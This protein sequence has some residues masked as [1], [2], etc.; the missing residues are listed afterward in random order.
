MARLDKD[1]DQIN[2]T[3]NAF[4]NDPSTSTPETL[5][6]MDS[7][8]IGTHK[9][10]N[11]NVNAGGVGWYRVAYIDVTRAGNAAQI[12]HSVGSVYLT[13]FYTGYKPSKG[14]FNYVWDGGTN[15]GSLV[16]TAGV[17]STSPTR[18]RMGNTSTGHA[19]GQGYVY[20]DLYFSNTNANERF[21]VSI[22]ANGAR[23]VEMIDPTL[24]GETP[25]NEVVRAT[26]NIATIA[27][28]H[29]TTTA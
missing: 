20:I 18:I 19:K 10:I 21:V 26:L 25:E 24:V 9:F 28:G 7:L 14:I 16:Q 6:F 27:T 3:L 17:L 11:T 15:L 5:Q 12:F 1:F 4:G 13:G 22:I 29:I 8:G 23:G 2:A